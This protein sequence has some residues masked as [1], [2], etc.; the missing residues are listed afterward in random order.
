MVSLAMVLAVLWAR[1]GITMSAA[2]AAGAARRA[3]GGGEGALLLRPPPP[4]PPPRLPTHIKNGRFNTVH[5]R[6]NV[7]AMGF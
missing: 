2:A 7:H 1:W 5:K 3:G 6:V 4:P